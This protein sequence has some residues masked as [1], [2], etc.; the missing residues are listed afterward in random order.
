[1]HI[2]GLFRLII[3]DL[4]DYRIIFTIEI[5]FSPL[6]SLYHHYNIVIGVPIVSKGLS[7]KLYCLETMFVY[8]K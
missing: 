8:V 1:M 6:S 2:V 4:S 5:A 7:I 3:P